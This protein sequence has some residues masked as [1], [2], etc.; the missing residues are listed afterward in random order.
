ML[1]TMA[2]FLPII[3]AFFLKNWGIVPCYRL[4]IYLILSVKKLDRFVYASPEIETLF[5][6][7]REISRG[8]EVIG[9]RQKWKKSST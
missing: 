4:Y 8:T 3:G 2:G 6:I 5:E 7:T 1:A 9:W